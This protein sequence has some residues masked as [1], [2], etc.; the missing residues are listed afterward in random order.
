VTDVST[1][2]AGA[3][4]RVKWWCWSVEGSGALVGDLIG[5]WMEWPLVGA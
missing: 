2:C 1:A 4:F 3:V 5:R